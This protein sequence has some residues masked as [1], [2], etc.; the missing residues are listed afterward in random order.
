MPE[1]GLG[2]D[3]GLLGLDSGL[4]GLDS[5]LLGLDPGL[6]GLGLDPGLL[7]LDSGE[8][9]LEPVPELL[10]LG[11]GLE[12]GL[13]GLLE[14]AEDVDVLLLL[15]DEVEVVV[16]LVGVVVVVDEPEAEN[17]WVVW[18]VPVVG[19]ASTSVSATC[20]SQKTTLSQSHVNNQDQHRCVS[21]RQT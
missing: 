10:G 15:D 6:L 13:L 20:I 7:G 21:N 4:L 16:L 11:L 9:G 14:D 1:A 19:V 12:A 3:S 5:G 18:K 2:L 8:L 17:C